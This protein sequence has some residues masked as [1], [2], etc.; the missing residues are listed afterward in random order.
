MKVNIIQRSNYQ[1]CHQGLKGIYFLK[2]NNSIQPFERF[3]KIQIFSTNL[4]RQILK[5]YLIIVMFKYFN[6]APISLMI[7]M[8][9]ILQDKMEN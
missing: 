2:I 7:N 1:F 6:M 9:S 8:K 3:I 5:I 4:K